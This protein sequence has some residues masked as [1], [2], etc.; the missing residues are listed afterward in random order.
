[1][2]DAGG[3]KRTAGKQ[4]PN[5]PIYELRKFHYDTAQGNHEGA[6]LVL[7]KLAPPSQVLQATDFPFRG[8][9]GVS[10]GLAKHGFSAADRIAIDRANALRLFSRLKG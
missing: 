9:A 1:M 8:G 6:L 5:A 10:G 7:L 3:H 4:A 2:R